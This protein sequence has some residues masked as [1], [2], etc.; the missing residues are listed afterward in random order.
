MKST[1]ATKARP[2]TQAAIFKLTAS[3]TLVE[4]EQHISAAIARRAYE[5]YDKRGR[6]HGH[7]L[8][9]FGY[10]QNEKCKMR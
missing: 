2:T 3:G 10:K 5:L 1:M 6:E 4:Q 8:D 7:D 9:D